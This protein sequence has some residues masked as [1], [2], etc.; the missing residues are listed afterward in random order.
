MCFR[1]KA[2]VTRPH[3]GV[4]ESAF[5]LWHC[6]CSGARADRAALQD[7]AHTLLPC[8]LVHVRDQRGSVRRAASRALAATATVLEPAGEEM[9][10]VLVRHGAVDESGEPQSPVQDFDALAADVVTLAAQRFPQRI[11]GYL[12]GALLPFAAKGKMDLRRSRCCGARPACSELLQDAWA[13][14]RASA[15]VVAAAI[16]GQ[17]SERER[18]RTNAASIVKTLTAL[19]TSDDD[20]QVRAR[21]AQ[22]LGKLAA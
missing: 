13:R 10:S 12:T 3:A 19:L 7:D 9:R 5:R 6:L 8:L 2:S 15:A 22:A 1:L 20:D 21:V 18:T 17:L 11:T 4:R 14:T 16:V